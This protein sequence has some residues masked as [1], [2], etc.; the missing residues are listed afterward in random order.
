MLF[1]NLLSCIN[2]TNSYY[3]KFFDNLPN[4]QIFLILM[5]C[6]VLKFSK[7][8]LPKFFSYN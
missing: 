7:S 4:T 6:V 3:R 8:N 5:T 1:E 2:L